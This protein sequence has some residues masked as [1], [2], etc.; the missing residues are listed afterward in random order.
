MTA[1]QHPSD[2]DLLG[3]AAGKLIDREQE[4]IARHVSE[5][6]G[7]REFVQAMEHVGGIFLERLP[8]TSMASGSLSEIVARIEQPD[9]T[10]SAIPGGD[11][12]WFDGRLMPPQRWRLSRALPI[13]AAIALSAGV[14]YTPNSARIRRPPLPNGAIR[15]LPNG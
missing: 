4:A 3:F 8:P 1:E 12:R 13:A 15:I 10:R 11:R 6:K 7:C 9:L 14:T 5:C 2:I